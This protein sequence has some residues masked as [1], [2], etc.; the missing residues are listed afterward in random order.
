M[1]ANDG[2]LSFVQFLYHSVCV[3]N[4]ADEISMR[5]DPPKNVSS[6]T[7]NLTQPT[8]PPGILQRGMTIIIRCTIRYGGSMVI[9]PP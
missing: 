8:D 4:V 2:A 3:V 9:D 1:V 6:G 7:L 5:I